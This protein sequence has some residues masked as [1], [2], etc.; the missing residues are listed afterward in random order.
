MYN[1]LVIFYI[2]SLKEGLALKIIFLK[3]MKSNFVDGKFGLTNALPLTKKQDLK[4]RK[5]NG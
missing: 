1:I 5:C 3:I 4:L 2:Q